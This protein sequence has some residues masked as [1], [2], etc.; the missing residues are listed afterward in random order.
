MTPDN[1]EVH[2]LINVTSLLIPQRMNSF[3]KEEKVNFVKWYYFGLSFRHASN[4]S[5]ILFGV[6]NSKFDMSTRYHTLSSLVVTSVTLPS[7]ILL[8]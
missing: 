8:F 5:C 7:Y 4:I 2:F 6:P 3:N 1:N